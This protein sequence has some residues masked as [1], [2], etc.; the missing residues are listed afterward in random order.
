MKKTG[1]L[2]LSLLFYTLTGFGISLTIAANVGVSSF[3]ALNLSLAGLFTVK[4]GTM[5]TIVNLCFLMLY[6]YLTKAKKPLA[7]LIQAIAVLSL[8]FVINF[9]TYQ[10]FDAIQITHYAS[11]LGLFMLG[12]IVA[13]LGTGMVLNLKTLAFPIESVCVEISNKHPIAFAKL[14][15]GIDIFSVTISIIISVASSLPFVVREGTIIS[16]VLLTFTIS[17]T[18]KA[19]E[20]FIVKK[21]GL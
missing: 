15:Y 7:Y 1:L 5:T 12:S 21:N 14:R 9:F 3:N 10:V 8:G 6:I 18:K 16:L 17:L 2:F 11:K 20:A 19:F 4:V 13:G